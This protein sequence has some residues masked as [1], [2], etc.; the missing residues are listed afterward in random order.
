MIADGHQ[1]IRKLMIKIGDF[2]KLAHVSIKTL[3]H[4]DHM[5][6]LKPIHVDRYSGYRYYDIGQLSLLNRILAFKDLGLSLEQVTELLHA[7]LSTAEMRGML[8]LKRMELATRVDEEQARLVRVEQRL[9][10]L[11]M[12]GDL[13]H[14]EVAVKDVPA[15]TAL[16]AQ[17]VAAS[18]EVIWPARASLQTLLQD[19]LET[20]RLKPATPWF[21]LYDGLPY[22]ETG[23]EL[24]LAVGVNL[25]ADQRAGDWPE[26]PVRLQ[27]LPAVPAM[28]SVIHTGGYDTLA[29]AYAALFSW[30]QN[31]GYQP[32]GSYRELYL[33]E[34]GVSA[35][36][37][38][39]GQ[40]GVIELQCPVEKTSLPTSLR[41]EIKGE[42]MQP[43]IVNRTAF[44]AVGL[45][46]VGKNEHGEISQMWN[47]FNAAAGK[48]Q[49]VND[50]E[51]FGLC[52]STVEGPSQPGEFEYVAC[53][54]VAD[55]TAIPAGMVYRQVPA[56]Q[57]AVFTHHGK[58]D[59]LGETY[60][61]IY[62]TG[63]AQA[64]LKVHPDKF[65]MEVYD[66]N[67]KLGSDESKFYIYVAIQ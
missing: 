44:K 3:H 66:E 61:Y 60:Q 40:A 29:Q 19:T 46:Y 8:R 1:K 47:R 4:Y 12:D 50:K 36:P 7:N 6:L 10:Q 14:S 15:Q 26:T 31:S 67:F 49:S 59:T 21:A 30:T 52:F 55:D 54:E 32:V 37:V 9:R 58:L 42:P 65:D 24:T 23:L 17:V 57:Y 51:A 41:S 53:F 20:A 38:L 16:V 48:I 35:T 43:K 63:L 33:P 39:P 56:Y 27:E 22:Q 18:E 62:N 25:R 11:E 45:S 64:G 13:L 2:S 34:T 5:G 28:A